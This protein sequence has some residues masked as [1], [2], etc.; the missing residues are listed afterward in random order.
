MLTHLVTTAQ[1]AF[2]AAP[3]PA[4]TGDGSTII[5]QDGILGFFASVIAPILLAIVGIVIISRANK[6]QVSQSVTSSGIA[7]LGI[8]ILAGAGLLVATGDDIVNMII[9]A[10]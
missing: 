5:N 10:K 7:I 3:S 4:P 2:L 8:V 1:A 6:G 9:S